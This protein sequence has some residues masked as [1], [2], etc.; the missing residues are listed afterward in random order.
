[1]QVILEQSFIKSAQK[2]PENIKI[3]LSQLLALLELN[4]YHP[5]LHTKKLRGDLTGFS[6]F[7]ITRDWR[8]IFCFEAPETIRVLEANHRRDIY[9]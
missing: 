5:L 9:R 8:V 1:M 7:R 4:P 3:K 6:S 2:L